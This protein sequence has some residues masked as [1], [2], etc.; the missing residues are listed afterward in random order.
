MNQPLRLQRIDFGFILGLL[1]LSAIPL[2]ALRYTAA[3]NDQIIWITLIVWLMG[4]GAWAWVTRRLNGTVASPSAA[5]RNPPPEARPAPLVISLGLVVIWFIGFVLPTRQYYYVGMDE[6][7]SIPFQNIW[8]S[9]YDQIANRPLGGMEAYLGILLT[10]GNW[11]GIFWLFIVLRLLSAVLLFS[12]LRR[13]LGKGQLL[14]FLAAAL[15]LVNPAEPSRFLMYMIPYSGA[16]FFLLL[17]LWLLMV[18]YLRQSRFL[19]AAA[20]VNMGISL[21]HY[22]AGFPSVLLGFA[23]LFLLPRRHGLRP[24]VT[25]MAAWAGTVVLLSA[26]FIQF[27]SFSPNEV[28]YQSGYVFNAENTNALFTMLN[29]LWTQGMVTF[30]YFAKALEDPAGMGR[31]SVVGL[32][33]GGLMAIC[34]VWLYRSVPDMQP[35]RRAYVI[36]IV[37]CSV[38]ILLGFA[39]WLPFPPLGLRNWQ[40]NPTIRNH[41]YSSVAQAA[42]WMLVIAWAVSWLPP[43][44][45]RSALVSGCAMLVA[46]GTSANYAQQANGDFFNEGTTLE[47]ISAVF[48]YVHAAHPQMPDNAVIFFLLDEDKPSPL[49][50]AFHIR[51]LSCVLFGVPAYQGTYSSEQGWLARSITNYPPPD[52]PDHTILTFEGQQ[53]LAFRVRFDGQIEPIR[54]AL[55]AAN[56]T[57][58]AQPSQACYWPRITVQPG[59]PLPYLLDIR[60]EDLPSGE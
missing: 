52:A 16:V 42:F 26:R 24:E 3:L 27:Y 31:F 6:P 41:H 11:E 32:I 33:V 54:E 60:P 5:R 35:S 47:K 36:G 40:E 55:P 2:I 45:R 1:L 13:L 22:E 14:P 39:A 58:G 21:L 57:P 59:E 19:L 12:L 44:I 51:D 18:S 7:V 23:V 25:W 56:T 37:L 17:A 30:A 29:N 28:T 4:V 46:L 9:F 49:G 48:Q 50:W 38:A 34:A 15:Y 53:V 10:P 43:R 20:C 8:Q